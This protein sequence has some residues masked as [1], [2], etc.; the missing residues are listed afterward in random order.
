MAPEKIGTI[1]KGK[2]GGFSLL[3]LVIV[4]AVSAV[5]LTI[6]VPSYHAYTIRAERADAIRLLLETAVC[7]ER[8]RANTGFYDTTRCLESP[9]SGAYDFRI[10]PAGETNSPRFAVFADPTNRGEDMCGSLGLDHTGTRSISSEH[11][12][13]FQCWAG[14]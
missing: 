12:T 14:R 1:A 7:Q 10:E 2:T 9:G 6:A 3:E 4:L 5:L 8:N 13:L 11:G